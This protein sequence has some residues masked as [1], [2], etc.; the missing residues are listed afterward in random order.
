MYEVWS[1]KW[2][3]P[4][5]EGHQHGSNENG[6]NASIDLHRSAS[7]STSF[8]RNSMGQASFS[9]VGRA[10]STKSIGTLPGLANENLNVAYDY[11]TLASIYG[12]SFLQPGKMVWVKSKGE[13]SGLG[14]SSWKRATICSRY[15]ETLTLIPDKEDAFLSQ[16][17]YQV[18]GP[19]TPFFTH[20]DN[21]FPA[22]DKVLPDL[23]EL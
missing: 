7:V 22:N 20:V 19:V 12:Q 11:S 21:C 3:S 13:V 1:S 8:T 17:S 6:D 10:N 14:L 16:Q 4:H 2:E 9:A 15:H 18:T 23:T 5:T